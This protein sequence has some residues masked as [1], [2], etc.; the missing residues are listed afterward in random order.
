V[1]R[2]PSLRNVAETPP[3]FHDG[4]AQTLADTVKQMGRAQ[5]HRHLTD[6]QIT[7][8]VSFLQT[9]TGVYQSR[10][11]GVYQSR[12]VAARPKGPQSAAAWP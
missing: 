8:I 2:V 1:V 11:V 5:L 4:S 3:Y 9:L 6:Q 12:P 7:L 10:P